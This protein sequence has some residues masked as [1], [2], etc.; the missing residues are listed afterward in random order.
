MIR[1]FAAIALMLGLSAPAAAAG[2]PSAAT[3]AGNRAATRAEVRHLLSLAPLPGSARR[4]N[5]TPR[6]LRGGPVMGTPATASLVDRHRVYRVSMSMRR[7]IGW[8]EAHA[9]HALSVSGS[10][11]STDHGR[12]V[13]RGV[14]FDARDGTAWTEAELEVG[15]VPAAHGGTV[16]RVDGVAL[17][18]DPRPIRDSYR[19]HR[20]RV[21]AASGCP[22]G[23]RH[24][25]DVRNAGARLRHHLLPAG[26]V[27]GRATQVLLCSYHGLNG[28]PFALRA[29][30]RYGPRVAAQLARRLR[31]ISLSHV[32]GVEEMCPMDDGS[33]DIVDLGFANRPDVDIWVHAT[34]CRADDNGHIVAGDAIS[35]MVQRLLR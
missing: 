33:A 29:H 14:S 2:T 25:Q 15:V 24:R 7:S 12:V 27:T 23:D 13:E 21:T 9:P 28:R 8:I 31:G 30:R 4:T 6:Q 35:G 10:E 26:R 16:W 3:P 5:R 1:C 19:G 20:A 32:D 34:G 22:S 17:W 11:S 18:L